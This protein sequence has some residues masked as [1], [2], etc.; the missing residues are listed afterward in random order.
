MKKKTVLTIAG[1]DSSGGAGIQAD[2]KAITMNGVYASS[3]I[4]ALTAQNTTGVYGI[5]ETSAD[6]IAA[7]MDAVFSR[8]LSRSA[9]FH[10]R[11]L[12]N[13]LLPNSAST[14][15]NILFWIRS[16]YLQADIV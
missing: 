4:T 8:M 1:S 10:L 6:F 14:N 11:R 16:W 2:I 13:V 5:L 9:C 3:V 15:Q 7:Q 12:W